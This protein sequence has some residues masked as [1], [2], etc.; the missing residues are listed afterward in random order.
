[1]YL[2]VTVVPYTFTYATTGSFSSFNLTAYSDVLCNGES[3]LQIVAT[4]STSQ[5]S[6]T[7]GTVTYAN[8][9]VN[10]RW[11]TISTNSNNPCSTGG[12]NDS[13]ASSSPVPTIIAVVVVI[14]AVFI[15]GALFYWWRSRRAT[16]Y[17]T[18]RERS[19]VNDGVG[20]GSGGYGALSD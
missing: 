2:I 16:A 13:D 3:V 19:E 4:S 9:T 11:F 15:S 18:Q 17:S 14:L 12:N 1:M 10:Q 6:C 20:K 5:I 8:G 7:P